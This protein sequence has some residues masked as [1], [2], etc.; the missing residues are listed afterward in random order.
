MSYSSRPD[1]DGE[2]TIYN[3][4]GQPMLVAGPTDIDRLWAVWFADVL[5]NVDV[6][7]WP[8]EGL[9]VHASTG[10]NWLYTWYGLPVGT[11]GWN[12]LEWWWYAL[13]NHGAT[14][15][16]TAVHIEVDED[17]RLAFISQ[18]ESVAKAPEGAMQEVLNVELAGRIAI[19][20]D[21]TA[22]LAA[23]YGKMLA[24]Q[25]GL[26][27]MRALVNHRCTGTVNEFGVVI[28]DSH[29]CPRHIL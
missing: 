2:F 3:S 21:E 4:L 28:H 11:V 1:G 9:R 13:D 6:A 26:L 14:L 5:N 29:S 18:R 23:L 17:Q 16:R 19:F 12:G 22:E 10:P 24:R 27:Y 20:R 25:R 15:S 7:P 8:P